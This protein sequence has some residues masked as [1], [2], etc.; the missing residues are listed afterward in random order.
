MVATKMVV[1]ADTLL[2]ALV[3]E[4]EAPMSS[5]ECKGLFDKVTYSRRLGGHT[6]LACT[7]GQILAHLVESIGERPKRNSTGLPT[8]QNTMK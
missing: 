7:T 3:A 2:S 8:A 1:V 6:Q 4:M 5:P